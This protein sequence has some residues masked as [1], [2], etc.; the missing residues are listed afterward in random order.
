MIGNNC[1]IVI[2]LYLSF[3]AQ[4][5]RLK[6]FSVLSANTIVFFLPDLF[7]SRLVCKNA[8]MNFFKKNTQSVSVLQIKTKKSNAIY[9]LSR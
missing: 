7:N 3:I 1:Q 4:P 9:M 8:Q 2:L 5:M 6:A